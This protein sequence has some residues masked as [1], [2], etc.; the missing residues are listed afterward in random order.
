MRIVAMGGGGFAM[1]PRNPRMDRWI[2]SLARRKRPRV[3]FIGTASGDAADYIARFHRAFARH[4]CE[5]SHL[6]LFA[7]DDKDL[8]KRILRQ[9]VIYVGGGN[10]ANLLAIWRLHGVDAILRDA[11]S[12]G[13]LLCGVSAGAI[14]WFE[15]GLT[16]S[17]G[18]RLRPLRDGLGILPGS[19]CPHYNARGRRSAYRRF[20]DAGELAEGH[21]AD[22]GAAILFEETRVADVFTSRAEAHAFRVAR[23][24]EHT[25]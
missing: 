20:I 24:A 1:E 5:P 25:I 7:R 2:L 4:D 23:G 8:R 9:D 21:A 15:D 16:D 3:M 10:T 19:F 13:V 17:F 22:D 18:P 6:A 11:W 14:C 12:E